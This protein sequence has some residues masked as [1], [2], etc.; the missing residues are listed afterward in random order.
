M[1]P[2][3]AVGIDLGTTCCALSRIDEMGRSVMVRS[4]QGDMLIPSVVFFEDEELLF[5]RAANQAAATQPGRTA[6]AVK[7]DLGQPS[8]ARAIGGELLPAELIEGC[9]LERLVADLA[10][11][12]PIRPAVVLAVPACFDHAQRYALLD[13]GKIAGLDLLGTLNDTLAA[14]L[15]FAETQGY[16][17]RASG[18]KSSCRAL[19]FDLGG[20]KLDVAIVEL[21]PTQLR[22]LAV[23]GD[24]RLGGRDWDLRLADHL[25]AAFAKKFG[26][27]PRY[28]M[29]SVRRLL[30]TAEEAKQTLTVRQQARVHVER[31]GNADDI[32]LTRHAFEDL[33]EDLVDRARDVVEQVLSRAGVAWRD[34]TQLLMI[35]GATRMPAIKKMLES[36]TGL[37]AAPNLHADEAVARGA[38]LYAEHLLAARESRP[39]S[40]QVEITDLTSQNLGLEWTD[41]ENDRAENVV[42]I[43]RGTEL[44][45]A[46]TSKVTTQVDDQ[47]MITVQLLAGESRNAEECAVA[48]LV[49]SDLPEGLPVHFPIEVQYQLTPEGWLE[50]KAKMQRTGQELSVEIRRGL[51]KGQVADWKRVISRHEGLKAIHAELARQE[52]LKPVPPLMPQPVLVQPAVS[53]N[54]SDFSGMDQPAEEDEQFQLETDQESSIRRLGKSAT[55]PRKIMI[56]L[57][58]HVISAVLGLAIGYYILM[59]FRPDWNVFHLRLPFLQA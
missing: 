44:P 8:Y 41:P 1:P 34:L 40:V 29:P 18:E 53:G 19:V 48:Q 16:L 49:I 50:V 6:E 36:H 21:K 20:G 46:T 47:R 2:S 14:A 13:A 54:G 27:D 11:T 45:C 57:T 35:G 38:A 52:A 56:M 24:P 28:D 55:S 58:G 33:T 10:A 43:P 23:G 31:S 7:R 32:T 25:A 51:S 5:G 37:T 59:V 9:L 4:P 22:T 12:T 39:P 15:A 17:N 30:Q 3:R 42:L 26:D